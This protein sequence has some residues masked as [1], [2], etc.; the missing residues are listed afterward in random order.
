MANAKKTTRGGN[1]FM[2]GLMV[3]FL[4][5][6]MASLAVIVFIKGND[7]PFAVESIAHET[8]LADKIAKDTQEAE[9]VASEKAKQY[10]ELLKEKTNFD[11]YKV[12]TGKE[13]KVSSVE[14]D[15]MVVAAETAN[16]DKSYYL[17]VGAYQSESEADKLKAKLAL[18]G[19]EVAVQAAKI[20]EKG[21]WYRVRVGPM[22]DNTEIT[23]IRAKLSRNGYRSDLIKI[24]H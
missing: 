2:T 22:D 12:L 18:Q 9:V 10:S 5:G 4:M 16:N 21:V 23:R 1:S 19:V 6:V 24:D 7:S 11:L 14:E 13:S 15:T 17:Q 20:P 3:G 8:K